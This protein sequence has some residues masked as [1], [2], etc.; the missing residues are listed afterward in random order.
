MVPEG[1]P[2]GGP[3]KSI[4]VRTWGPHLRLYGIHYDVG[5]GTVSGGV[6]RET[7]TR[8]QVAREMDVIAR[9]LHANAVRITGRDVERLALAGQL[10]A[11]RGLEVWLSPMLVNGGPDDTLTLIEEAATAGEALRRQGHR[12]V[13]VVG[14][15]LS[16]FLSGIIPGDDMMER[17]ALL[18]DPTRL[19]AAV[20]TAG[21]DPAAKATAFL[22]SAAE[23]ARSRFAGHVTYAA[24]TWEHVDWQPFDIVGVD[25]YRDAAKRAT[26][27][28]DLQPYAQHG[29][30]VVVTEFGCATFQGASDLGSLAWTVVD[31][32][33]GLG[34]IPPN[35]DRDEEGQATEIVDLL[36]VF[37]AMGVEGAFVYTFI[38]PNYPANDS[39]ALDL[40]RASYALVRTRP[41]GRIEPKQAFHSVANRYARA[42][43]EAA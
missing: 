9:D 15:E 23:A 17:F 8:E 32:S 29:K 14:V 30:P 31:R 33:Q 35:I 21:D 10:A 25:A 41:D 24:G 2:P 34:R 4:L 20:M 11:E 19:M 38:A 43:R 26:F 18:S 39:A 36:K 7:L 6:S 22:E 37:G 12:V 13:L 5:T 40:D 27:A 1:A 3:E 16:V 42:A 28:A